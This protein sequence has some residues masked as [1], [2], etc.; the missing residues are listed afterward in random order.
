MHFALTED[1]IEFRNAVANILGNTS[2]PTD[3]RNAWADPELAGGGAGGGTGRIPA[4]WDALHE[5]G[6]LG[7]CVDEQ[8]GGLGLSDQ[9][10]NPILMECGYHGLPDPIL[11]TA[12][13]AAP[14]LG[15]LIAADHPQAGVATDWLNRIIHDGASIGMTFEGSRHVSSAA[16]LDGIIAFDSGTIVLLNP[17]QYEMTS[18]ESVDGA[19]HLCHI[20][21]DPSNTEIV[22]DNSD[23]SLFGFTLTRQ[24]FDRAVVGSA[25][26]LIGLSR[27][28]LNMTVEYAKE[29]QQFGVP[30]GSFQAVKHQ[31]A[32]ASLAVE[33]AEPLVSRGAYSLSMADQDVSIHASMAKAKASTAAKHAGAVSLQVHGAI[34]YTVECDLH[35]YLKRSWALAARYGDAEFHR[36]RIR[37]QI[38]QPAL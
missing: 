38:T 24:A 9:D 31:L 23:G 27:R 33:F 1:Q 13:V 6:L 32:D 14:L 4:A 12:G 3:I 21:W 37:A 26:L 19:R 11:S 29:R 30:I 7:I 2:T 25:A 28:M 20:T 8:Y 16:T 22:V 34:G 5:M 36:R 35:L 15:A 18:V 10:L 17:E